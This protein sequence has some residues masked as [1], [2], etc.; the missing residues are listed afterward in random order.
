VEAVASG[1]PVVATDVGGTSEIVSKAS[2]QLVPPKD[3]P[4]LVAALGDVLSTRWNPEAIA[5]SLR[6]SWDD[7]AQETLDVCRLVH[8]RA[9]K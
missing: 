4:A 9:R 2:G 5:G 7:V 8:G 3:V 6:R 1:R